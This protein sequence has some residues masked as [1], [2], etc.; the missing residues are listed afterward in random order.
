[1]SNFYLYILVGFT[2]QMIS[3]SM[4]MA[5]GIIGTL[6]L[7]SIGVPTSSASASIHTATVATSFVSGISHMSHGN[8]DKDLFLK[9]LIP[10]A[11]G[12]IIGSI[13]LTNFNRDFLKPIIY[14]YLFIT[15]IRIL[16]TALRK[17]PIHKKP[18]G[19]KIYLVGLTAGILDAVGGGGWGPI[20]TSSLISN[21]V[22][23]R[24]TVGTVDSSKFVVALAQVITFWI[25][26]S[27][28]HWHK[29]TFSTL[30]SVIPWQV[31]LGL[32]IGGV[33]A[34]PLAA[35]VSK[36]IHPEKLMALVGILISIISISSIVA[37]LII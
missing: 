12:G 11:A 4:G 36:I 34:A 30:L 7:L 15:G 25:F 18:L 10:G 32:I 35:Y 2:A 13:L 9:L 20:V 3:G 5:Y 26:L 22:E 27:I 31:I 16:I 33:T 14:A 21:G 19:N 8:I 24:K 1:M 17:T 28:T 29:M 23:A 6:F 37:G